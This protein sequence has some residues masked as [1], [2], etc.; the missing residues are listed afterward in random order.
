MAISLRLELATLMLPGIFTQRHNHNLEHVRV[1]LDQ[2]I[3]LGPQRA[4][5]GIRRSARVRVSEVKE[6][7]GIDGLFLERLSQI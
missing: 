1:V 6:V 7:V 3:G 4:G 2:G 5:L